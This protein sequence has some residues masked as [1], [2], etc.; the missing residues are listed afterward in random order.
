MAGGGL[1]H[2]EISSRAVHERPTPQATTELTDCSG[3]PQALGA[4]LTRMANL[5]HKTPP[6]AAVIA[7]A[8][9][10]SA[11]CSMYMDDSSLGRSRQLGR[12]D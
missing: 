11:S 5:A 6:S 12:S 8:R 4:M 10:S 9:C 7:S 2:P 3:G 1:G